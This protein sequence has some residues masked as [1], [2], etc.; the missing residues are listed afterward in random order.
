MEI[1]VHLK[2]VYLNFKFK[3]KKNKIHF[4]NDFFLN[5]FIA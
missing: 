5:F 2:I 1:K 3:Q 4:R